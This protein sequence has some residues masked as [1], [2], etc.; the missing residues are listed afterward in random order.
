MKRETSLIHC[1]NNRE[2]FEGIAPIRGIQQKTRETLQENSFTLNTSRGLEKYLRPFLS[3]FPFDSLP[4]LFSFFPVC[5]LPLRRSFPP[6]PPIAPRR[7]LS[8]LI[9]RTSSWN[10]KHNPFLPF[11]LSPWPLREKKRAVCLFQ[12]KGHR[13]AA[14]RSTLKIRR[15]TTRE[16]IQSRNRTTHEGWPASLSSPSS[17]SPPATPC[18][19]IF[20]LTAFFQLSRPL[21]TFSFFFIPPP[22]LHFLC[23]F[24]LLAFHLVPRFN[25][26]KSCVKISFLIR[27]RH[28][29]FSLWFSARQ[30]AST[31]HSCHSFPLF[32]SCGHAFR[33]FFF[34]FHLVPHS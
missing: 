15:I 24:L 21:T 26:I 10:L 6:L 16:H 4:F 2:T 29:L 5:P 14:I 28:L 19:L 31:L 30:L 12:L 33:L 17:S 32:P 9:P 20:F 3:L 13:G 34:V 1:L 25:A 27:R 22:P 11:Y 8:L 18:F 7:F 23:L